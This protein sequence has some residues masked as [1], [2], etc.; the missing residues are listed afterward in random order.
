MVE[1]IFPS[2]PHENDIWRHIPQMPAAARPLAIHCGRETGADCIALIVEPARLSIVRDSG[3]TR[4][5]NRHLRLA[6]LCHKFT[7]V[8]LK[9]VS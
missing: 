1:S 5:R 2:N 9:I 4:T 3:L 6:S 8:M 7:S